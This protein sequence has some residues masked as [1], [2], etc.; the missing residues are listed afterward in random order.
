VSTHISSSFSCI[1]SSLTITI[2]YTDVNGIQ[3]TTTETLTDLQVNPTIIELGQTATLTPIFANGTGTI[4]GIGT[5]DSNAQLI[6]SPTDTTSYT[7][8]VSNSSGLTITASTILTVVQPAPTISLSASSQTIT[9][10]QTTTLTWTTTNATSTTGVNFS[11]N[12]AV[13]GSAIISPVA[14]TTYSIIATGSGGSTSASISITVN[15][16]PP[17]VSL[18]LSSQS[19]TVGQS[20]VLAWAS[21][22]A[23]STTGTNF[24]TGGATS[25]NVGVSPTANTKYSITASGTG[26]TET[27]SILLVVLPAKSQTI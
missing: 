18:T 8:T 9:A 26:G 19:I 5:V 24:S 3:Q 12:G 23:S 27:A 1:S 22:N 21:T 20:S 16:A 11:T 4:G 10:G 13:S 25:G 6:V 14:S 17:T 7:L 2:T 15:P